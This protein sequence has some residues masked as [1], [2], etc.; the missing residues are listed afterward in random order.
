MVET[1]CCRA[2]ALCGDQPAAD[3]GPLALKAVRERMVAE[4]LSRSYINQS[5]NRIRRAFRWA[6]GEELID[7]AIPAA[8]ATVPGL[9]AGRT[10]AREPAPVMPVDDS[11]VGATVEALPEVVGDMVRLQRLTGMRPGLGLPP[12]ATASYLS[13]QRPWNPTVP[14]AQP[15]SVFKPNDPFSGVPGS[16]QFN[17]PTGFS[18]PASVGFGPQP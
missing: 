4:G 11:V 7:A 15:H 2:A 14:G 3:F 10:S 6:A 13:S 8:L 1:A 18:N 12:T 9:S 5:V 16:P 17:D